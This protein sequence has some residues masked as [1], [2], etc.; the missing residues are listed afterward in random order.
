V[1]PSHQATDAVSQQT[2]RVSHD[3]FPGQP[4][5]CVPSGLDPTNLESVR[6][7]L[8]SGEFPSVADGRF[9][10]VYFD[11]TGS[12]ERVRLIHGL[13]GHR[14]PQF[15]A[16][17]DSGVFAMDFVAPAVH[18][19]EYRLGV[20]NAAGV[21]TV[22]ND[23][24]CPCVAHDPFGGKSVV[25]AP[26]YAEPLY[27]Q[28]PADTAIGHLTEMP[29]PGLG[30]H[31]WTSWLWTPPNDRLDQVLP[32]L[33]VLDGSDYLRFVSMR[34]ILE[35]LVQAGSLP[36][37]RAVFMRPNHRDAEYSANPEMPELLTRTIPNAIADRFPMPADASKRFAI[38]ASLGGLCL[39]HAHMHQPKLFGGLLLQSGSFFQPQSDAM[40]NR[41]G[42]FAR[43]TEF[44][45]KVAQGEFQDHPIPIQMTCGRGGENLT[46]N[47]LMAAILK[48]RRFS[49]DLTEWPDAHNWTSWRDCIG[50]ALMKLLAPLRP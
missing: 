28:P 46:N 7:F 32:L 48:D 30:G 10:I 3:G 19:L 25:F 21:E 44:V 24:R 13:A 33:M 49:L 9:R 47:R 17:C 26:G 1:T 38:G 14:K 22:M 36:R 6:T 11:V 23:P 2:D 39:L 34:N 45:N 5:G 4:S 18:R 41:F 35:N 37:L 50:P 31:H 27:V 29:V 8:N 42:Y 12:T 40:E 43:I 15:F 20:T 16:R